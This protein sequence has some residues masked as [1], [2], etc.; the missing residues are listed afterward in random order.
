M[1]AA[2]GRTKNAAT[3]LEWER[4]DLIGRWPDHQGLKH[5]MIPPPTPLRKTSPLT[6]LT[7]DVERR[8]PRLHELQSVGQLGDVSQQSVAR[9]VRRDEGALAVCFVLARFVRRGGRGAGGA[10]GEGEGACARL[11][12]FLALS[13]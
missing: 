10:R 3:P 12:F 11:D 2:S 1:G 8:H 7:Y 9:V 5:R 4:D 13:S 6:L